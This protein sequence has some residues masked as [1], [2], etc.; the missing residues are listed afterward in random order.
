M[1]GGSLSP[2]NCPDPKPCPGN[3]PGGPNGGICRA[4]AAGQGIPP[5]M[6]PQAAAAAARALNGVGRIGTCP[7]AASAADCCRSA[8]ELLSGRP[9]CELLFSLLISS[10]STIESSWFES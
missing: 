7:A 4:A 5:L 6:P 8:G 3:R 1:R 9:G 2:P 10:M